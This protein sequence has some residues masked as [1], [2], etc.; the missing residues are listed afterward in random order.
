MNTTP[1]C[2]VSIHDVMPETLSQ[3]EE[4]FG[5]CQQQH[6]KPITLLVVPG[7][8]WSVSD[9]ARLRTMLASGGVL[10]GHGWSHH[11]DTASLRGIGP[12]LHSLLI[13][14]DVAEHLVLDEVGI[15][16]LIHRCHH[17]FEAN[18]LPAPSLYV[19]PAWAMGRLGRTALNDLPFSQYEYFAGVYFATSGHF[20]RSPVVGFEATSAWRAHA[21]GAWNRLARLRAERVGQW[22]I[23]LHPED[24]SLGLQSQLRDFLRAPG[25]AVDYAELDRPKTLASTI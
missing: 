19:P 20:V 11:I 4:L 17:W 24:L 25:V 22:R 10:A 14:K 21:V 7:K 13:S 9:L 5:L 18:H 8:P 16:A 3:C 6:I 12:K 23:S 2:A 1:L 15:A